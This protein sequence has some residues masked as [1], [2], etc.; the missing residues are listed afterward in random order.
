MSNVLLI[1]LSTP[2]MKTSPYDLEELESLALQTDLNPVLKITQHLSKPS[3]ATAVGKGKLEELKAFI[4]EYDLSMIIFFNELSNTQMRNLEFTLNIEVI[5]RTLLV[6][7]LLAKRA[8]TDLAKRLIKITQMKYLLPRLSAINEITDRQQGGIG[9]KGPGETALELNRRLL[10][11][12]IKH[13]EKALKKTQK[14]RIQNRKRRLRMG[15]KTIAIIG[16]TNAGKSTLMNRL[17]SLSNPSKSVL[18]KNQVFST[19]DTTARRIDLNNMPPFIITDTVGFISKMPNH[20]KKSFTAT[21]EE[22]IDA[23]LIIV[24]IDASS[25]Y[26]DDHLQA[27]LEMMEEIGIEHKKKL[28]ILNKMDQLKNPSDLVFHEHPFIKLSLKKEN[29]LSLLIKKINDL[30]YEDYQLKQFFIPYL[31]DSTRYLLKE[32]A[33]IVSENFIEKGVQLTAFIPKK[34]MHVLKPYES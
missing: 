18:E 24:V 3:A 8:H 32:H 9:L 27:T 19:L 26:M 31:E 13:E 20:L 1:A 2:Q 14:V 33:V 23:D 22:S 15:I 4:H 11:Q 28:Y 6:L 12:S 10:E 21:L 17:L 34:L 5:D 25:A 30:L 29:D 16:Y 7:D